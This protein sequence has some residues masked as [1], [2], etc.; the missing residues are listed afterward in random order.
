MDN[1]EPVIHMWLSTSVIHMDRHITTVMV[2][3]RVTFEVEE[4]LK[5]IAKDRDTKV[6][7]MLREM[8]ERRVEEIR[9]EEGW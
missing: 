8:I 3:A 9:T 4:A 2:G 6:G 5:K 1:A 7:T